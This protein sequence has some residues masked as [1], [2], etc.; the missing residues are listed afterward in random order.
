MAGSGKWSVESKEFEWLIRGGATG[1]RIFERNKRFQRSIFLMK[2]EVAWM[3]RI[4]E[5]LVAEESS[6][7]FWDQSRAG[8]P[9]IMAQKRSNRHGYFLLIEEFDGRR[10]MVR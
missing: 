3:A 10:R 8:Y 1:V 2:E 9:R 4:V 5:E 7:V 6:E